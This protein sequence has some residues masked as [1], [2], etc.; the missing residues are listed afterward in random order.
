[1]CDILLSMYR[2]L[3][4]LGLSRIMQT[5]RVAWFHQVESLWRSWGMQQNAHESSESPCESLTQLIAPQA[6]IA[7]WGRGT[8]LSYFVGWSWQPYF[9]LVLVGLKSMLWRVRAKILKLGWASESGDTSVQNASPTCE[10]RKITYCQAVDW[11]TIRGEF[12][13]YMFHG[14]VTLFVRD[15]LQRNCSEAL[16]WK[17][18]AFFTRVWLEG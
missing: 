16:R 8:I 2:G 15:V 5:G 4:S 13:G 1:M 6:N 12:A 18:R 10:G 17:S 3:G 14:K 11:L 7:G 9:Q